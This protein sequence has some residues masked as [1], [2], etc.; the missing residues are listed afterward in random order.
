M[1]LEF[2]KY[3]YFWIDI[4]GFLT[5]TFDPAPPVCLVMECPPGSNNTETK[6]HLF[7]QGGT[8]ASLW[9]ECLFKNK[10]QLLKK[11]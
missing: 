7:S 11:I 3:C 6:G 4:L 10:F 5:L 8:Q 1:I 9:Q 2:L